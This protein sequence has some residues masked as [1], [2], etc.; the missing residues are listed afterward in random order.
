[1]ARPHVG[2]GVA[3]ALALAALAT[4]EARAQGL[5]LEEAT[6]C[7]ERNAP[8]KTL[9][10]RA[11]FVKV[12]R[13]GGERKSRATVLGK[14]LPDG[15]RRVVLRFDKPVDIRGTAMLMIEAKEGPS[16][17]Y[18]WSPDDRKVRRV[19]SRSNG[20]LFG[21]DFSYDDFENWR[22]FQRTGKSE[23]LPDAEVAKRA[24]Y[25]VSSAPSSQ[26][27]SAYEKIVTSVDRETCVVLQ[28]DSFEHGGRLRKVLRADPTKVQKVGSLYIAGALELEDVIDQTHTK[29]KLDEVKLDVDIPDNRFRPT[30]LSSGE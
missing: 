23:R 11:D 4:A 1:M 3:L 7:L 17:F 15:L 8:K 14:L 18:V 16:D 5:S 27:A 29:V 30:D 21:T 6:S 13:L 24:V 20:G 25:V 19:A 2:K 10:F 12:D 26:E 9:S 28:V 22:S